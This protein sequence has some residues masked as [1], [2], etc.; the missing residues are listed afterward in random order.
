MHP[1]RLNVV[2]RIGKKT[3]TVAHIGTERFDD[4]TQIAIDLSG[5]SREQITGSAFLKFIIDNFKDQAKE[6]YLNRLVK[7]VESM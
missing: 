5:Q 1:R 7:D 2:Q 4:L 3:S 6:L